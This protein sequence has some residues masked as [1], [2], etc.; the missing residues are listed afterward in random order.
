MV[1]NMTGLKKKSFK[2][3]DWAYRICAFLSNLGTIIAVMGLF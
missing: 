2:I 1:V 3:I